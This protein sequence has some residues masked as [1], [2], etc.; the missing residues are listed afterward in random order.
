MNF[1]FSFQEQDGVSVPCFLKDLLN[2]LFR[3]GQQLQ[4]L[5]KLLEFSDGVGSWNPTSSSRLSDAFHMAFSKK[6]IEM[7]VLTRRDYYRIM[8]EKLKNHLPN[9]EFKY[10]QVILSKASPVTCSPIHLFIV[11]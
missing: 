8:M 9:L 2:P 6:E 4:V 3:A 5:I 7:I 11:P 1:K 10:H